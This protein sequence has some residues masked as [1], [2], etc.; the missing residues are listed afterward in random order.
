M[1]RAILRAVFGSAIVMGLQAPG[2]PD[3][4]T[5]QFT[6]HWNQSPSGAPGSA[7]MTYSADDGCLLATIPGPGN[8]LYSPYI[9]VAPDPQF[10]VSVIMNTISAV[11]TSSGSQDG[12]FV[13][14]DSSAAPYSLE[15]TIAKTKN[16]GWGD[17]LVIK[18]TSP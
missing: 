1:K 18:I 9:V 17:N 12:T 13:L 7:G 10:G 14:T 2:L 3:L 5:S 8:G 11:F 15:Y 4:A 16:S 6:V